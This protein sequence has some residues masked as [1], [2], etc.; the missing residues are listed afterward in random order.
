MPRLPYARRWRRILSQ[1]YGGIQAAGLIARAQEIYTQHLCQTLPKQSLTD[2]R[3]LAGRPLP[4]LAIYQA[5]LAELQDQEKVL[6]QVEPLFRVAFTP[7]IL[8]ASIRTLNRL[9]N[10]FALVRLA[11]KFTLRGSTSPG[12]IEIVRDDPDCLALN[13]CRCPIL[14]TLV[15]HKAAELAPL[16][17]RTDEWLAAA[18]PKVRFE[19]PHTL[20][21]GD[22]GYGA[23]LCNL[24]L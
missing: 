3:L 9:P 22:D 13:Q 14:D 20:A 1:T 18:L 17:C 6:Q 11:L 7:P 4:G 5:L 8:L 15:A 19:G 12:D 16:Y 24:W 23:R 2:R 21:Q 10:P